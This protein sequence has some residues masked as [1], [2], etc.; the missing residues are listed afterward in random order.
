MAR[1]ILSPNPTLAEIEA[2]IAVVNIGSVEGAAEVLRLSPSTIR[3]QLSA[4]FKRLNVKQRVQAALLL[5]PVI[6]PAIV[7]AKPLPPRDRRTGFL[8]RLSDRTNPT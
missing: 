1:E 5:W 8:R 4:L 3:S 7:I 2:L 6:E